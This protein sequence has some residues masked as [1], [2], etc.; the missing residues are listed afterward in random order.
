MCVRPCFCDN[1]CDFFSRGRTTINI[2]PFLCQRHIQD[3]V[4]NQYTAR[5]LR[6]KCST[7]TLSSS[8]CCVRCQAVQHCLFARSKKQRKTSSIYI[9]LRAGVYAVRV[10]QKR[11][12]SICCTCGLRLPQ[13]QGRSDMCMLVCA[14]KTTTAHVFTP[15]QYNQIDARYISKLFHHNQLLPKQRVGQ[16]RFPQLLSVW[17]PS[18]QQERAV[19]PRV[20][21]RLCICSVPL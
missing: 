4:D 7:P 3:R 20:C 16:L 6:L 9:S 12:A 5:S 1:P 14:K 8:T 15:D 11:T 2:L 10:Q 13:Q 21:A 19:L 18:V 17:S